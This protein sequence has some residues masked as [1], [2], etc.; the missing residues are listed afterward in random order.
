MITGSRNNSIKFFAW[1]Y[2]EGETRILLQFF[3]GGEFREIFK[4][5]QLIPK[6]WRKSF[7]S[8][9]FVHNLDEIFQ[10]GESV[11]LIS[12]RIDENESN[13]TF[14]LV[15][16]RIVK[17]QI[18]NRFNFYVR[19]KINQLEKLYEIRQ[20]FINYHLFF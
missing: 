11:K 9:Y 10:R 4:L 1:R 3:A 12:R 16:F 14:F 15:L 17:R 2:Y 6:S 20:F 8:R 5:G 19:R 7:G 13:D 18:F